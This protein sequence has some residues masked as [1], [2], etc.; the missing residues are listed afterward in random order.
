MAVLAKEEG[1]VQH[2]LFIDY[3]Q[4][5]REL[6]LKA[7]RLNFEK[8]GL[9]SPTIAG[10]SGYGRL[11]TSGLTD[12]TKDIYADAFLPCRNLFFLTVAAAFAFQQGASGVGIGLLSDS[13]SIFP[14]QTR[15]FLA[16]A[17]ATLTR[18]LGRAMKV[19]APLMTYS[20]ADVLKVAKDRGITATYSCHAGRETP[21]GACVACREYFG[22][23]V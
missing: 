14:D 16:D 4:L 12:P 23:E 7:C 22:L 13:F 19:V 9:P 6:E 3:G 11:V 10:L 17:Q 15:S 2:P 5:G 18:A 20:K 8:H 21:C 1:L